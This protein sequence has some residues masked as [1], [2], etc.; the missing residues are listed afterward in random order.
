MRDFKFWYNVTISTINVHCLL[1][2]CTHFLVI[3]LS[4]RFSRWRMNGPSPCGPFINFIQ[5]VTLTKQKV[6][7]EI[8]GLLSRNRLFNMNRFIPFTFSVLS[9]YFSF[10]IEKFPLSHCFVLF[11]NVN[12]QTRYLHLFIKWV[13]FCPPKEAT[14]LSTM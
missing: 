10:M 9:L 5:H 12:K 14:T 2:V 7:F 4:I 3:M 1:K 8:I 6:I 13:C 11:F